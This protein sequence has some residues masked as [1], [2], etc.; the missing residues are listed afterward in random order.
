[1][2]RCVLAGAAVLGTLALAGWGVNA[3]QHTAE[4]SRSSGELPLALRMAAGAGN[5][6]GLG[7][8]S[9]RT[10]PRSLVTSTFPVANFP[11]P[12]HGRVV[13][14][15]A[16][17]TQITPELTDRLN[18]AM[19]GGADGNP[20][21]PRYV[22]PSARWNQGSQGD[23]IV[24]RWSLVPDGLSI[25]SGIGEATANSNLFSKWDAKLPRATW[26]ALI[27]SC[28][29]RWSQFASITYTR[30]KASGVDWDD[31]AA[32]GSAG[33]SVRG[34]VRISMKP[35]DGLSNVLA[36]NSYPQTGDM[37][38]DSDDATGSTNFFNSGN[39]YRF[40]RNTVQ[41]EHGHGLGFPHT[42]STDSAIIME[43]LLQT[44]F[45]GIRH[46][47]IRAGQR[48]YGDINEPDNTAAAANFAGALNVGSPFTIGLPPSPSV[49]NG[50]T[51][52]IDADG[53]QDWHSFS[54]SQI[55]LANFTLTPIGLTYDSS[56]QQNNGTCN[57]GNPTNSLTAADLN[58]TI[59]AAD[60]V[61]LLGAANSQPAG[62]AETITGVLLSPAGTFY[63]RVNEGGTVSATQLYQLTLNA[64]S[65]PVVT[66]TDNVNGQVNISW[67]AIPNFGAYR[68]LRNTT[69]SLVGATLIGTPGTNS[70]VDT[71]GTPNTP[72]FYFVQ[73]TQ[74][75]GVTFQLV[76]SDQGTA[77][78]LPC[79]ADLT[80]DGFV[81]DS[82][83]V[84]FAAAYD[85]FTVPPANP[86]ADLNDDGF[87]D[88]SD[89]V[90]FAAAYDA[91]SCP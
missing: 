71:T 63:A 50:S 14:C 29:T 59:Y 52:S 36:Y 37:V 31:G 40:F 43:P 49:V 32:W 54:T 72:Y 6:V 44:T 61:T 55:V 84:I 77:V 35:I 90:I 74:P 5:A 76:G 27:E 9:A 48:N 78:G 12:A 70:F 16:P 58:L 45:D 91:F 41:H 81:D 89:F 4:P 25:P 85:A 22:G 26:I 2:K 67:T 53:E 13:A 47:D 62:S 86:A 11:D 65:S 18:Q 83:F 7:N 80:G 68:V 46:D 88:D 57:T 82:D 69:N 56:S 20:F 87:V 33:S 10:S 23:P 73:A 30:V 42:C 1:M 38:L 79:P 8:V 21:D 75:P 66:A 19:M 64:T 60:G 24:L 17:G 15:L 51:L 28:F 3:A 34:D 39:N